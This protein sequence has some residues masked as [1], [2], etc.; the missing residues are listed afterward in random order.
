MFGRFVGGGVLILGGFYRL[1]LLRVGRLV[2]L[3]YSEE[4]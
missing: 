4:K 3:I 1:L 2:V